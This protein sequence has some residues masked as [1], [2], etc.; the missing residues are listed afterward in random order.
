[1]LKVLAKVALRQGFS[2]N[3]AVLCDLFTPELCNLLPG[4]FQTTNA[5]CTH[6]NYQSTE[7]S[8]QKSRA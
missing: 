3:L 6:P 8:E 1:M 7:L 2:A 4:A 5:S